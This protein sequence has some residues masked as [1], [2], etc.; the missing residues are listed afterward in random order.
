MVADFDALQRQLA[1]KLSQEVCLVRRPDGA[2]MLRTQFEFPDGDRFPIHVSE[3]P[4]GGVCLSD[5]GHTLMHLSYD[6]DLESLLKGTRGA[7]LD[8][9]VAEAGLERDG[10]VMR[11]EAP[12]SDL[13]GA[14]FRFGQ[15]LTRIYDLSLLSRSGVRSTFYDDLA[16]IVA[17]L[18]PA[19]RLQAD[20]IPKEVPNAEDYPVDY[21]I[22]CAG[23]PQ[24]FL[25]GIANRD[26]ARLTTII[27]LHFHLH[28]LEFDSL[29]VFRDQEEIPRPDLARLSNAGGEMVSSLGEVD[30]LRRKL[31]RR[32]A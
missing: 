19:N 14:V 27:L 3:R 4:Y 21:R 31:S 32:V 22:H 26:K 17:G 28:H 1:E 2:V 15:A 11:L 24:L 6:H 7:L 16:D 23:A 10:G 9:I 13:P 25:Y 18:V 20:Y 8:R 5:Q 12:V 30:H 29:L